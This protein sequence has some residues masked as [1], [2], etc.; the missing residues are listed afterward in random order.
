MKDIVL[1]FKMF[2]AKAGV[3]FTYQSLTLGIRRLLNRK[4]R[5][6][7]LEHYESIKNKPMVSYDDT[8]N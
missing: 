4:H 5:K 8:I 3:I 2:G 1:V 6:I 7:M